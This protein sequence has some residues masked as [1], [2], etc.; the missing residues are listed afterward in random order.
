[1]KNINARHITAVQRAGFAAT[2]PD[3]FTG[4]ITSAVLTT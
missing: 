4:S 2:R 1:M 3:S